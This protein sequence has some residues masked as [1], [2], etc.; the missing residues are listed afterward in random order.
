MEIKNKL[1]NQIFETDYQDKKDLKI[2]LF[3]VSKKSPTLKKL[4]LE[5][6]TVE[7]RLEKL[8]KLARDNRFVAVVEKGDMIYA[9]VNP[10]IAERLNEQQD[11][12]ING[13][14]V[15]IKVLSEAEYDRL[16]VVGETFEEYIRLNPEEALQ[17]ERNPDK[18][19]KEKG[20]AYVKEYFAGR[21]L[22][23]DVIQMDYM[24]LRMRNIPEKIKM[25]FLEKMNE[26]QREINRRKKE[27]AIKE[28]EKFFDHKRS[29][30]KKRI[31]IEE[32]VK[33]EVKT[34]NAKLGR[35]VT[36]KRKKENQE[37]PV[38]QESRELQVVPLNKS[39]RRKS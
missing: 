11:L 6:L 21:N 15:S 7:K 29:E 38:L 17:D 22:L 9:H 33:D 2:S 4:N 34:Q 13:K 28:E 30:L 19:S 23:S 37:V 3:V 39:R 10:Q 27:D 24:I 8:Q 1:I 25:A 16:A 18:H 36:G 12:S 26:M 35:V 31:I 14:K 5:G 20:Y 32:I